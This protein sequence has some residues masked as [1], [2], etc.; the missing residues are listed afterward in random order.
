MVAHEGAS[1]AQV[2]TTHAKMIGKELLE[3]LG[4]VKERLGEDMRSTYLDKV[5]IFLSDVSS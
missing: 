4:R 3:R 5:E 2:S 1:A